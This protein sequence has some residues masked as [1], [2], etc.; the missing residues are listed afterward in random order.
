[1]NHNGP[2]IEVEFEKRPVTKWDRKP[3]R[4]LGSVVP[5][6][7]GIRDR[8]HGR[9]FFHVMVWEDDFGTTQAHYC[10]LYFFFFNCVLYFYHYYI[11]STSDHEALDS[12]GWG[13]LPGKIFPGRRK[14][15][16][17]GN[18]SGERKGKCNWKWET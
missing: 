18:Q 15:N 16:Y 14:S 17:W 13:P 9:Q 11:C 10:V 5:N 4:C 2:Q 3:Q 6:L 8:F 1:M 7:F 12:G